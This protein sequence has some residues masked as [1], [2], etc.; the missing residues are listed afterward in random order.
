MEESG[1][2]IR[3]RIERFAFK[4]LVEVLIFSGLLLLLI[5][6][7]IPNYDKRH[8]VT[9][10][11]LSYQRI[12]SLVEALQ[13]YIHENPDHPVFPPNPDR[14]FPGVV[15]CPIR[16]NTPANLSFLTTPVAFLEH[17][18]IDPFIS[19]V[20]QKSRELPPVV[21]HWV[22]TSTEKNKK[23]YLHVAWGG[24]S[25]GP[26]LELPPQYDITVLRKVP[27]E[28]GPLRNN[29]YHPS[30][31]LRSLGIIYHDSLGNSTQL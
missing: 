25:V 10:I 22:Q 8:Q 19:Q 27:Y 3:E 23:D 2:S 16:S 18:P 28:T 12:T 6:L 31:G 15:L 20:D 7:F 13:I 17:V 30:N 29:L 24:L 1:N 26:A 21:L 11:V 9:D 5:V 14:L 4:H